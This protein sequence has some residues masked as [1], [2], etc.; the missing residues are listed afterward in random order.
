[1]LEV[2]VCVE[3]VCCRRP[4]WRWRHARHE[5]LVEVRSPPGLTVSEPP[6]SPQAMDVDEMP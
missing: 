6:K 5:D 4:C 3:S 1:M 2:K